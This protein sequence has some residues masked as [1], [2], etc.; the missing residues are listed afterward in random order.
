MEASF[1]PQLLTAQILLRYV[2]HKMPW[3]L[4]QWTLNCL[5]WQDLKKEW[6]GPLSNCR[7]KLRELFS[8]GIFF[9]FYTWRTSYVVQ[10]VKHKMT[11]GSWGEKYS[12]NSCKG[13]MGLQQ[14]ETEGSLISFSDWGYVMWE[15]QKRHF[16]Q[17]NHIPKKGHDSRAVVQGHP[18]G[19]GWQRVPLWMLKQEYMR[20]LIMTMVKR[21][22][23]KPPKASLKEHW[24]PQIADGASEPIPYRH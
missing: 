8:K 3:S 18:W 13:A 10:R 22:L 15:H 5:E 6:Q 11:I 23:Q 4:T 2:L 12:F 24:G 21:C 14:S 19:A 17:R 9:F 20:C 7:Q 16:R 1:E